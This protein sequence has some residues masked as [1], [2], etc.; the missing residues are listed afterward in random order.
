[1]RIES[2]HWN[3]L[4]RIDQS[5]SHLLAAYRQ[6]LESKPPQDFGTLCHLTT[7]GGEFAVWD[8]RKQGK[9][10]DEFATANA[11]KRVFSAKAHHRALRITDKLLSHPTAAPLLM[12]EQELAWEAPMLGRDCAG[13]ID[14]YN[15]QTRALVELKTASSTHPERFKRAALWYRYH[16]QLAWYREAIRAKGGEVES[17]WIVGVETAPPYAVTVLEL[18]ERL[19]LDGEKRNR[20]WIERLRVCEESDDWPEYAQGPVPF[21]LEEE[22]DRELVFD[23]ED[24][25]GSDDDAEAAE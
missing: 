14:V 19:L 16:A 9:K 12:G 11:G 20:L 22:D 23:D 24:E 13:T 3:V 17:C 7:F 15:P 2:L 1:M 5:P 6:E 10:W 18:T 4:K 8:G 21:D 25:D